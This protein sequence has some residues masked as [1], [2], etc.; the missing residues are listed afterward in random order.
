MSLFDEGTN[1]GFKG[2]IHGAALVLMA[3]MSVYHGV[4]WWRTGRPRNAAFA[5]LYG[6]VTVAEP[7]QIAKHL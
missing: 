4:R 3:L 1:D 6:V 7:F 5:V 2:A